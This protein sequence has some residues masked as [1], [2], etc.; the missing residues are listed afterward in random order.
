MKFVNYLLGFL[1]LWSSCIFSQQISVDDTVS[2]ESLIE[3][4]L[5]QNSCVEITNITSSV[6]GSSSGFSSYAQFDRASSNFP[7]QNGI[8]LSTGNATSGGN[9]VTT[10]TLSEGSTIWGT[11]PDLEAALG[12]TNTLNATSIEFDIV[13]ISSQLQ[14]NYLLAS[15]EY[16]GINPCQLSDGFAFLIKETGSPLPYQNIALVPGT[17]TPVNTNTIHDEIF[18]VCPAQNDQYFDG[19]NVGDT[20]YNGRT[21]VLT[22]ATTITPYVQYHIKLVIADQTDGTFDSA[23]FIEG[24]SFKILDLGDD[25]TTCAPTVTLDADIDNPL[26]TYAWFLDNVPL[27]T[28]LSN[29]TATQDGTYRV[30]VTVDLNG[31][32]CVE[33]DE[34]VVVLNTEEPINPIT[35]YFLCDDLSEDGTEV[36]D[37]TTKNTEVINNIPFTNYDFSYHLSDADARN[38]INSVSGNFSNTVNPQTI[39]VR[40]QDLDSGC[41]GFTTFDLVVSPIPNITDPTDLEVCDSDTVPD[42]YTVIDL[43]QKNDEITGGQSNLLVT[44]HYSA[45]DADNGVNPI[46]IPYVNTNTPTEMLYIRV[47]NTQTGCVNTS[48]LTINITTSPIVNTNTQYLDACDTDYDGS[49]DFD[50]TQVI[51]DVLMG[52]TGVTVTFHETLPDAQSGSNPVADETNYQYQNA[53]IEPG[54]GL[55][56]IRILD[57]VTGCSSIVPLEVHTNL[58]LTGTDTGDFALC[59][60]NDDGNDTLEFDLTT[61]ALF[62]ANELPNLVITFYETEIERDTDTNPIDDSVLYSATSPTTL[63]IKIDDVVSGCSDFS[64][65]TLLVNPVLLFNPSNPLPYC[66]TDD[67]GFVS[68]DLASLDDT[69]TGGNPNFEVRYYPTQTDAENN[70]NQLPPFYT[71]TASVETIYAR[72]ENIDTGCSTVNP[73]EIEV[74]VAPAATLPSPIVICDNDQDGFSIINLD[75]KIPETVTSTTGINIDFFTSFDDADNDVNPILDRTNYNA[76]TQTVYIRVENDDSLNCY[77]IVTLDVTVNTLPV[78]PNITPFQICKDDGTFTADF[79]LVDKD[80]EILNGQTG[81]EVYYFEDPAL[82]I[83]IDKNTIYQNNSTPQTIYIRVENTTDATCS[84]TSSFLLQVSS[85]PVYN[86]FTPYLICDD[87]T[88]DQ[89]HLFDLNEKVIEISQGSPD[90]LNVS[91]HLTRQDAE[92][93]LNPQPLQYT[94]VS[95]PQT[96]YVRIES[97]ASFCY[98]VEELGINIIASPDITQATPFE[99]CDTDYDGFVTFNLEDADFQINDRL[100][101]NLITNYFEDFTDINQN[102]GLDNSNEIIDPVNYV[103]NTRTVYIKVANILTGCFSVIPLDLIV[104]PPPP[105]NNISTIEI[106]DNDTYTFDLTSVNAQIVND[107]SVVTISYHNTQNDADNNQNP[108][109][110]IFNYTASNHT[111][112]VRVNDPLI[113]CPKTDSFNLQI[114]TNPIANTAPD[115]VSCDDDFDGFLEF[116][117]SV[118]TTAIIG[119]QNASIHTVTYYSDL[120]SAETATNALPN[121]HIAFDSEIIYARIQ[122]NTTGCFAISQFTTRINPL[123]IIPIEDFVPLCINNLPLIISA[124]TGNPNDSYLWS[125]SETSTEILLDDANDIGNYW[126]TVTTPHVIGSDCSYTKNFTVIESEDATINFTTKVDFADPN[127]ITVDVSGIGDYVFILDDGEPQTSNIFNNVTFGLHIVTIRDL[128][129]CKDVTTEVVVIDIPKFVTPN[130]DGAFDTWHIVG[131]QEIPGTVVYIYNRHGK[132]LKTLPHTSIGWDGTFNGQ[133]MPSDDYWFVAEIIQNGKSFNIKGHFALKR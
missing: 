29:I 111:I 50:L 88:N 119:S 114:N 5:V 41:F 86:S 56:Y 26:A 2:L 125:T 49:A 113:N 76:N 37:L 28:T 38:N 112:Y 85:D 61:V 92:D 59:D 71:N 126:V 69:V 74:Y 45:V 8:M 30:E 46:P 93:N 81:K 82:T 11:D 35:D 128:N 75:S 96:L 9:G 27:A 131:V 107:P 73:F 40:I 16:F 97:S 103:S 94:N 23:V 84:A 104:V 115:L 83:P 87:I 6:N 99:Q 51:N 109:G 36:F 101:N 72:I 117:L 1:F 77:N 21:T 15:E 42:G 133:N 13:S 14:F 53:V 80:A 127:S 79:L 121:L 116:D 10:P 60:N 108:I 66:D 102:D 24:N 58:L 54:S 48:S 55:L 39:Y 64:E 129:G 106:C 110:N 25:V 7:F 78:I 62:I 32:A 4:N 130:N 120:T 20:N 43:S 31:N 17:S 33:T 105:T 124:N 98:V 47:V 18:G 118:N 52:L 132:L 70:F 91:F 65:I 19:Y 95:N 67:D 63:Y 89:I 22:A 123:P 34:V 57:D 12:V 68:I 100:Q 44:Y 3:N 90:N 122:N